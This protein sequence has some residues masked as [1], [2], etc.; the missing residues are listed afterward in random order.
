MSSRSGSTGALKVLRSLKDW[1]QKVHKM[2]SD[3][4]TGL[5]NH[6]A[7]TSLVGQEKHPLSLRLPSFR[8][9]INVK[10]LS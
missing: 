3:R 10:L 9:S 7:E 4:G 5:V 6:P 2:T 8:Q 1:K